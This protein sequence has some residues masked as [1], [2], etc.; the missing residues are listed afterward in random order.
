M[1]NGSSK[2]NI[3]NIQKVT[4]AICLILS[5]NAFAL[6]SGLNVNKPSD[7]N[8]KNAFSAI[9]DIQQNLSYNPQEDKV[10]AQDVM[11]TDG[12]DNRDF[13]SKN[14]ASTDPE[15][16]VDLTPE[17]MDVINKT[18]GHFVCGNGSAT[19]DIG[20]E[21]NEVVVPMHA[22]KIAKGKRCTFE[23]F[24]GEK[25]R[26]KISKED[27]MA[28]KKWDADGRIGAGEF[29]KLKLEKPISGVEKSQLIP[30][31]DETFK[32]KLSTSLIAV[33]GLQSDWSAKTGIKRSEM[34]EPL[35]YRCSPTGINRTHIKTY[36]EVYTSNC[37]LDFGGSGTKLYSRDINGSLIKVGMLVR[38]YDLDEN[39]RVIPNGTKSSPDGLHS[40]FIGINSAMVDGYSIEAA[41]AKP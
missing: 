8:K 18:T 35:A 30:Y 12:V 25:I 4:A 9:A 7:C 21:L 5:A 22:F 20:N 36:G 15:M 26:V 38:V 40:R 19:I 14:V 3:M 27:W 10:A 28:Y 37:D 23:T 2:V 6:P 32:L 29:A 16:H 11:W 17:E 41:A 24:A 33:S 1:G 31:K 39:N 34:K 13:M